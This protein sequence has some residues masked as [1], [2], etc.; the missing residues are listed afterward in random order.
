MVAAYKRLSWGWIGVFELIFTEFDNDFRKHL[1]PRNGMCAGIREKIAYV[2]G[3][4]DF[5]ENGWPFESHVLIFSTMNGFE[6]DANCV[7]CFLSFSVG[8]VPGVRAFDSERSIC[9][10]DPAHSRTTIQKW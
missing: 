8:R 4:S 2:G 1:N 5:F 6:N 9:Q 3:A 10:Y 7:Q